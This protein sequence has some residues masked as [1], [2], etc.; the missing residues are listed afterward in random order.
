MY[1]LGMP[2]CE[3]VNEIPELNDF[4]QII[5]GPIQQLLRNSIQQNIDPV[6]K[7]KHFW[8]GLHGLIA[9]DMIGIITEKK[10]NEEVLEDF[11]QTFLSGIEN[12]H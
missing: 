1:G 9:L 2:S 4:T 5:I 8:S 10:K 11:I 3:T 6:K 7:F 12:T